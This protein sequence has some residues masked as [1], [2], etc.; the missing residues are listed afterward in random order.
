MGNKGL[1]FEE[2]TT[3]VS[4]VLSSVITSVELSGTTVKLDGG[5]EP[6]PPVEPEDPG[7]RELPVPGVDAAELGQVDL[8]GVGVNRD[9]D[10]GVD[11]GVKLVEDELLVLLDKGFK[12]SILSRGSTAPSAPGNTKITNSPK[13]TVES[14]GYVA[15]LLRFGLLRAASGGQQE[16]AKFL[17]S[18]G[19]QVDRAASLAATKCDKQTLGLFQAYLDYGWDVNE[20]TLFGQSILCLVVEDEELVRWLL[21]HGADPNRGAHLLASDAKAESDH[22]SGEALN[23]AAAQSDVSVVDLLLERDEDRIPM[24]ARLL[25]LGV[26]IDGL[27]DIRGPLKIG[28]PLHCAAR[29]GH[30]KRVQYLLGHGADPYRKGLD[31]LLREAEPFGEVSAVIEDCAHPA[32]KLSSNMS[33]RREMLER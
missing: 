4:V 21:D 11:L 5:P 13:I 23:A 25:E 24:M 2:A 27:D 17:L 26:D 28:T 15:E 19:A 12:C 16:V 31:S 22:Y 14:Q 3:A 7:V 33:S 1:V 20:G 30:T 10:D 9:L 8:P 18:K 29:F 6:P 32:D